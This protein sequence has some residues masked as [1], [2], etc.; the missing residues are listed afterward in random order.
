V[1]V[2]HPFGRGER[3]MRFSGRAVQLGGERALVGAIFMQEV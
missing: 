3:A 1:L 2:E